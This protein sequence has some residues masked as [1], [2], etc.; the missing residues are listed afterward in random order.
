MSKLS[1]VS[2][3]VSLE[4][5]QSTYGGNTAENHFIS[6]KAEVP[7]GTE[8]VTLDE[9]LLSSLDM[10]L[11]AFESLRGAELSKGQLTKEGFDATLPKVRRRF[12]KVKAFLTTTPDTKE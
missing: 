2:I 4:T 5:K 12:E 8:G 3:T 7:T 1:V 6:F 10:H 9:A 11:K